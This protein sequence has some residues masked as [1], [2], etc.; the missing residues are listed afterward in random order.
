M[1]SAFSGL[2]HLFFF[3]AYL[4]KAYFKNVNKNLITTIVRSDKSKSFFIIP[5]CNISFNTHGYISQGLTPTSSVKKES[6]AF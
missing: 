2:R 1:Q 4:S 5:S 3:A 6:H